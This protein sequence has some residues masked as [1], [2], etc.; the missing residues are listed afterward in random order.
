MPAIG[1]GISRFS[2]CLIMIMT[3]APS[4][5][6]FGRCSLHGWKLLFSVVSLPDSVYVV[7]VLFRSELVAL[8][9]QLCDHW[10]ICVIL[11][12]VR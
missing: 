6:A 1:V 11:C 5:S 10:G 8:V 3:G 9:L 7:L 4:C 2:R 12:L